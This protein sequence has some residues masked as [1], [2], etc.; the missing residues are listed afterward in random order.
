MMKALIVN[1]IVFQVGWLCCV[2]PGANHLPSLGTLVALALGWTV[3]MPAL[4]ILSKRWDGF[5]NKQA[6]APVTAGCSARV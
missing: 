4:M 2:L 1:A 3:F 6:S 5:S